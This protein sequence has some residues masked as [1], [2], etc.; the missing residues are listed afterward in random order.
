MPGSAIAAG[1]LVVWGSLEEEGR[2]LPNAF[3]IGSALVALVWVL[4]VLAGFVPFSLPA[5]IFPSG[6]MAVCL[7]ASAAVLFR[8]INRRQH[9]TEVRA[10]ASV[11]LAM[12]ILQS[13]FPWSPTMSP[14]TLT[15]LSQL[16][17]F[18]QLLIGF[19]VVQLHFAQI[20]SRLAESHAQLEYQLLN[21]LDDF[22]PLCLRCKNVRVG[23]GSWE[24]LEG[25]LADRTGSKVSHGLCP[26]CSSEL[27]PEFARG[28]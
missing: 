21:A 9:P 1:F 15:L 3:V 24:T 5:L 8:G 13:S 22:I 27:Y 14:S 6:Y 12:G 23:E 4:T 20:R 26:P 16:S 17:K 2:P 28:G 11:L 10:M 25:Y 19:A 18:L 7:L